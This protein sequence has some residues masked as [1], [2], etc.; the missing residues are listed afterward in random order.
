[1]VVASAL[2]EHVEY[3]A[4]LVHRTPQPALHAGNL[5]HDFIQVPLVASPGQA[6]ADQVGKRLTELER[7]LPH[8]S[9]ADDDATGGQQFLNQRSPSG[10]R[11][12]GHTA[13]LIIAAGTR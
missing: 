2:D 12:Y 1:L 7:P 8:G 13:W 4:V 9:M 11:K 5:Q 3:P 6:A 10:R